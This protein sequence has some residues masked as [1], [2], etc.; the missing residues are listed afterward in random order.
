MND[1]KAL[2]E[3]VKVANSYYQQVIDIIPADLA[4]QAAAQL[5]QLKADRIRAWDESQSI[6]DEMTHLR[7]ELDEMRE[8]LED[9]SNYA[10]TGWRQEVVIRLDKARSVLAKYP[11]HPKKE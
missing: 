1:T 5:E 10:L 2:E 3:L 4:D 8:A 9:L 6:L 7:A 11:A